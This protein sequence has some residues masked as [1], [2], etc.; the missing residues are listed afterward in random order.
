MKPNSDTVL[1]IVSDIKWPM[2][3]T[4]IDGEKYL[5]IF[6]EKDTKYMYSY[7]MHAKNES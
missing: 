1:K 2:Y 5:Q 4:G 6:T 3:F 7:C